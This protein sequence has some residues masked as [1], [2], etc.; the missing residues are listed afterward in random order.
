MNNNWDM[1]KI[2]NWNEFKFSMNNKFNQFEKTEEEAEEYYEA[3]TKEE[4]SE[5]YADVYIAFAGLSRFSISAKLV[6]ETI[7]RLPE[8]ADIK[9]YVE[10]KMQINTMREFDENM[11]HKD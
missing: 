11:H 10:A 8:W 9:K 2:A 4:K 6:C 5:E 7:E 3:T 1:Q